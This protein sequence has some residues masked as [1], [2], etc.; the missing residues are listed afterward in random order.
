MGPMSQLRL[1]LFIKTTNDDVIHQIKRIGYAVKHKN[2]NVHGFIASIY[3]L[4]IGVQ[5]ST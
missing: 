3:S 1:V 2:M 4:N 5:D